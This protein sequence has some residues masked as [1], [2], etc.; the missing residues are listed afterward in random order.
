MITHK[1]AFYFSNL[2]PSL[3]FSQ[4]PP[5]IPRLPAVLLFLSRTEGAA[6]RAPRLA[7]FGAGAGRF[8]LQ[9]KQQSPQLVLCQQK[10]AKILCQYTS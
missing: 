5:E 7:A 4:K 10:G 1:S 8:A 9:R 6:P 3:S 2:L